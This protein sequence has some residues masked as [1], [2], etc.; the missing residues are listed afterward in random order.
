MEERIAKIALTFIIG[1]CLGCIVYPATYDSSYRSGLICSIFIAAL[2]G[3][4]L[5][6]FLWKKLVPKSLKDEF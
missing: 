2:V 3:I 5:D 6:M 1:I 4:F